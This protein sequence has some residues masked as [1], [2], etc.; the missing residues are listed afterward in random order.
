MKFKSFSK[1]TKIIAVICAVAAVIFILQCFMGLVAYNLGFTSSGK[2]V[3]GN[4]KNE[5]EIS[6]KQISE[7][8]KW[9]KEN[10]KTV[11][12]TSSDGLKLS[13]YMLTYN[14]VTNSYAVLCH[15]YNK[16]GI[17][18]VEY[19][20]HYY[21][22]GMNVLLP[23]SR[24]H[25]KSE[26]KYYG[27]G[28]TEKEDVKAWVSYITKNYP[29]ARILLHGVGM[30]GSAVAM[31]SSDLPD[32]VRFI[33]DDG[34]FS[35]LETEV[36][37]LI[38]DKFSLPYFPAGTIVNMLYKAHTGTNMKDVSAVN[39]LKSCE[40]P[41]LFIHAEND[42]VVPV[43]QGNKAFDACNGSSYQYIVNG[44]SYS[45]TLSKDS[46]T[47]WNKTDTYILKYIGL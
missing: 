38:K 21:G 17:S 47:Y 2:G 27:M 13:A 9:L 12:V 25:G 18:M 24:G 22:L 1:K 10:G 44:A 19:A 3:F 7:N 6:Q 14:G 40:I 34:G 20:K 30:G 29:G 36:K 33:I 41:V 46:K 39:E 16:D 5:S 8:E 26:G 11:T 32:N 4:I 15:P 37:Y 43:T 31:A 35:D 28:F 42:E 45:E 23:D